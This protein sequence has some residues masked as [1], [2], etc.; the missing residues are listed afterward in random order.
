MV[1]RVSLEAVV[2]QGTGALS[3]AIAFPVTGSAVVVVVSCIVTVTLQYPFV[4]GIY[5]I[6]HVVGATV[7]NFEAVSIAYFV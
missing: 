2:V 3:A 6:I 5:N 4:M 7:A 1:H